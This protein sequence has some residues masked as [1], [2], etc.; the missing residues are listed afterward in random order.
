M[1]AFQKVNRK[2][3]AA[4]FFRSFFIQ[5]SWNFKAM[6][7]IGF[8]FAAA[9]IAKRLHK[10]EKSI[11]EF[12]DRHLVFFNAHPYLATICLGACANLEE[13]AIRD[14]EFWK[15]H[16]PM[17]VFKE[18]LVGPLGA[19][20]DE[21]FW[22]TLKPM[23]AALAVLV[24]LIA[25][26]ISI[27]IFLLTYNIPHFYARI[28]GLSMGYEMGFEI[29]SLL[30]MRRLEK[31]PK[32]FAGAGTFITGVLAIVAATHY[33]RENGLSP[34]IFGFSGLVT[35]FLVSNKK[36]VNLILVIVSIIAVLLSYFTFEII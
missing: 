36:S 7:G 6:L 3:L 17:T 18:R 33:S 12:V 26:W 24:G 5:G 19:I 9:P 29:V 8:A 32:A 34:V 10:D 30:S 11:K 13:A 35:F 25:G 20:G 16:R 27:P 4:V 23:A 28:K 31:Y 1:A 14:K 22:K 15:D 21:I 2:D